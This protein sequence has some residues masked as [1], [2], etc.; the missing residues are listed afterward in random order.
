MEEQWLGVDL[1]TV[2]QSIQQEEAE[3]LQR[4]ENARLA[5]LEQDLAV[6]VMGVTVDLNYFGAGT[7]V[8]LLLVYTCL[9]LAATGQIYLHVPED[10]LTFCMVAVLSSS[11]VLHEEERQYPIARP[12]AA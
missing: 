6:D 1:D 9:A 7:N 2:V 11:A 10:T 3:D 8:G 5:A 4:Q 12:V